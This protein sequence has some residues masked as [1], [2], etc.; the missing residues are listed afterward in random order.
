MAFPTD[1]KLVV[2]DCDGVIIDSEI[3]AERELRQALSAFF[4]LEALDPLLHGAF[5]KQTRDIIAMVEA[6]FGRRLPE[7]F[8]SDFHAHADALI[9]SDAQMIPGV[10]YAMAAVG[11]PLAIASN[12]RRSAVERALNRFDLNAYVTAGIFSADMVS[13]PKPDPAVYLA[14]AD[15]NGVLPAHCIAVEDSLTGATAALGAGMRVLGF[16]GASHIPDGHAD[17]LLAL[18][19]EAV[20]ADMA[21]LTRA[22]TARAAA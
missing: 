11:V 8:R 14:A 16:V 9:G 21:S 10:R 6:H 1:T 19:V 12:S 4:P 5:G 7:N 22:L 2:F 20:F 3:I 17:K 15:A 13:K 18:G